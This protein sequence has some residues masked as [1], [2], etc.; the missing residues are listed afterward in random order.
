MSGT[1]DRMRRTNEPSSD[2]PRACCASRI[3]PAR[4]LHPGHD[5]DRRQDDERDPVARTAGDERLEQVVSQGREQERDRREERHQDP[6]G[7]D[8]PEGQALTGDGERP[9]RR[10]DVLRG[11]EEQ[12]VDDQ[13]RKQQQGRDAHRPQ[14]RSQQP[15][16]P[17]RGQ[18]RHGQDRQHQRRQQERC[19]QDQAERQQLG[20]R[21]APVKPARPRDEI[22]G[23]RRH[24]SPSAGRRGLGHSATVA[25]PRLYIVRTVIGRAPRIRNTIV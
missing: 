3:A 11:R 10:E 5:L 2:S 17:R 15:G 19:Q 22:A 6:A 14:Q 23:G 9:E 21:V 13:D 18:D 8:D 12:A 7:R 16:R 1:S 20:Q 24:P 4:D 25:S